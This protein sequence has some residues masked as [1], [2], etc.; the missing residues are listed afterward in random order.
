MK[1]DS[2]KTY[3]Y[4][5]SQASKSDLIVILYD[6]AMESVQDAQAAYREKNDDE[7]HASLKR[8]KRVVDELESSLDM[9]YDISKELFK[10]YVSMM[11]FL[12]KADA[13]HDVTVLDTVLSMLSKLRKSFYEVSRQDTTGPVMRNAEQVYAGL[14]YSNMGTSTEITGQIQDKSNKIFAECKSIS[15]KQKNSLQAKHPVRS[16]FV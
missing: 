16:F 10:I 1:S 6:I 13:G 9:Q 11:R 5:V 12:V 7:Y 8:A 14:T 2:I 15:E 3:S 4:R